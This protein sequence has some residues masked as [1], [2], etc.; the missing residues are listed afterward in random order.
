MLHAVEMDRDLNR[1]FSLKDITIIKLPQLS[2]DIINLPT[3]QVAYQGIISWGRKLYQDMWMM[4]IFKNLI[5]TFTCFFH[6]IQM[7]DIHNN[8]SLIFYRTY[9]QCDGSYVRKNTCVRFKSTFFCTHEAQVSSAI[10]KPASMDVPNL[11]ERPA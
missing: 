6:E 7:P 5:N 11:R 1:L 4:T 3:I 8:L 9:P 10:L 2:S